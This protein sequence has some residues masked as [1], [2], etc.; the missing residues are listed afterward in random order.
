G[1]GCSAAPSDPDSEALV[2]ADETVDTMGA[3]VSGA[4]DVGSEL[5]TTANVNLRGA[6]STS[7]KILHVVPEGATVIVQAASPSNG[8]YKVSHDGTTGWMFGKYLEA[9]DS[10]GSSSD[11][12]DADPPSSS[13]ARDLAIGRAKS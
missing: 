12:D 3:G 8:F 4:L 9:S 6:A 1:L 13:S 5:T 2:G 10:G 11:P 7:A